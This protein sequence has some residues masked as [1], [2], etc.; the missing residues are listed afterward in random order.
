[1]KGQG[2]RSLD[3][4]PGKGGLKPNGS[5]RTMEEWKA[6]VDG[7]SRHERDQLYPG[8]HKDLIPAYEMVMAKGLGGT[9][10]VVAG[11][12]VD[13]SKGPP[14]GHKEQP[15]F[16]L[17][18]NQSFNDAPDTPTSESF[19]NTSATEL[20]EDPDLTQYADEMLSL[21]PRIVRHPNGMD[22]LGECAMEHFGLTAS[23]VAVSA[24]GAKTINKPRT[25]VS[26]GGKSGKK[27]SV[28]STILRKVFPQKVRARLGTKVL[29]GIL[30]RM[31]PF[32]GT[33][34]LAYDV[35][36]ILRCA[37]RKLR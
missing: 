30:G 27:T 10:E 31:V 17:K 26:G 16:Q 36:S 18:A 21:I 24:S 14:G 19:S 33:A 9:G 1:M 2:M 37:N 25:G 4:F 34:I 12:L 3:W 32:A 13:V 7:L 22:I 23:G 35:I 6:Y 8:M 29:G 11:D 20:L 5:L 15:G 28:A